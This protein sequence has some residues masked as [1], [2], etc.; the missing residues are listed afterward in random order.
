MN[1]VPQ[2]SAFITVKRVQSS[3][4]RA[5]SKVGVFNFYDRKHRLKMVY[6]A[7]TNRKLL[8]GDMENACRDSMYYVGCLRVVSQSSWPKYVRTH[9]SASLVTL[10]MLSSM[11]IDINCAFIALEKVSNLIAYTSFVFLFFEI[12]LPC[13]FD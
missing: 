4:A 3:Q 13:S 10:C 6:F 7:L 8:R 5:L 9:D 12:D 2:C 11:I 1:P